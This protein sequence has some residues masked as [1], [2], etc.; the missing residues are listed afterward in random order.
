MVSQDMLKNLVDAVTRTLSPNQQERTAAEQ[1]LASQQSNTQFP[2]ALL[3]LAA[4]ESVPVAIR[5]ATAVYLKNFATRYYQQANWPELPAESRDALKNDL[6]NGVLVAPVLV[7]RQ[8]SA[9]LAIIAEH[10][11]PDRWPSLVVQ[12]NAPLSAAIDASANP[13]ASINWT[14]MQ[15]SLESL[16]AIFERYPNQM[17]TNE[18]YTEINKSLESTAPSLLRLLPVMSKVTRDNLAQRDPATIQLIVGNTTLLARIFYLLSWQDLPAFFEDHLKEFMGVFQELLKFEDVTIDAAADDEPSCIDLMHAAIVEIFNLYAGKFDEE[19]RPFLQHFV[20]DVWELLVKRSSAAKYD[21]VVTTGIKFLTTLSKSPD[22]TIFSDSTALAQVCNSIVVPNIQLRDED[23]ELFE[24]NPVEYIRLD[25]EGSDSET[26]RRGAVELVKGLCQHFESQVTEIFSSH[27]SQMLAPTSSWENRDAALYIVTALGWKSGTAAL[28]ATETSSLINVVDFFNS[29]VLP[30]LAKS[31]NAPQQLTAP[32]FTADLIKYVVSFRVQIPKTSYGNII[33]M[34]AKLLEAKEPV[35]KSYSAL[36][37][38]RLLQVKDVIPVSNGQSNGVAS[39]KRV[40][41]MTKEDMAP[42]LE[43][44]LPVIVRALQSSQR[45]DEYLMRL[46]LRFCTVSQDNMRP[47]C[48]SLISALVQVLEVVIKNPANPLFNHYLFEALSALIRFNGDPTSIASFENALK[49]PLQTILVEDV[50]EFGPYVFQIL[51]QM[52]N[53]HTGALPEVYVQ[54]LPAILDPA[55]WEKRGYIPSM[56]LYLEIYIKKNSAA[57]IAN[58]QMEPI[59]GVFN[60]LVASK[61]TD[62]LG[63]RLLCT[64]FE[65]YN[66]E[67]LTNYLNAILSVLLLRLSVATTQKYEQSILYCLSVFVLCYGPEA[68]K[69][70]MDSQQQDLLNMLLQQVWLSKV[71]KIVRPGERRVCA[72]ALADIACASDMCCSEP[73]LALWSKI[74]T[75]TIA[76]TEGIV[77][78]DEADGEDGEEENAPHL[79]AGESYSAAHSQLQWGLNVKNRANFIRPGVDPKQ[80]LASTLSQLSSRHPGRFGPLIE[81]GVEPAANR[82]LKTYLAGIGASIA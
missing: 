60:K 66:A 62:H 32:I 82:I 51:S 65:T 23:K 3:Q 36:C 40:P 39:K 64:V 34:C 59:L 78:D 76:L 50:T 72:L 67:P 71:T 68:L 12:L 37:I 53:V 31:A 73:Y 75:V 58:N 7:R 30:E 46:I 26:R 9:V 15:G 1:F 77:H 42:V 17:R 69:T 4:N 47:Y 5:Q 27:V 63:V 28:G 22:H 6:A 2:L 13:N 20:K 8:L 49:A 24:D 74:I 25:M 38:E 70:S 19:F 54:Y 81:S 45:A 35:V 55:M 43:T 29:Q 21:K 16:V 80:H 48:P 57:V 79:G 10:E 33:Q 56:V 11:Y 18:L 52:M 44:L 41:R 61:A 14:S